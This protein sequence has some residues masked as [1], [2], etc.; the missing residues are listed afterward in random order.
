M[1]QCLRKAGF[2]LSKA[3]CHFGVQKVNFLGRTITTKGVA[4]HTQKITKFFDKV[5]FPRS[6]EA[7]QRYIGFVNSY[8][9]YLPRLA[10]RLTPFLQLLE[11]TD[12]K[13]KIPITPDIK[14]EITEINEALDRCCHLELRQ[15][16]PGKTWS[17]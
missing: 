11:T 7:L 12:V 2:K 4:P 1:P 13:A 9:N 5:K 15:P 14:K 10:E 16:L 6:K 17:S 8:R 3:K